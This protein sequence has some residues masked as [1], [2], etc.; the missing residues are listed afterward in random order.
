MGANVQCEKNSLTLLSDKRTGRLSKNRTDG[1]FSVPL[2]FEMSHSPISSD[3][4]YRSIKEPNDICKPNDI[5]AL[6]QTMLLQESMFKEQL[7]ELHRLYQVQMKLMEETKKNRLVRHLHSESSTLNSSSHYTQGLCELKEQ[8]RIWGT[9][10]SCKPN[11]SKR[12]SFLSSQINSKDF[13][14]DRHHT[15]RL[16]N[17]SFQKSQRP[18]IDLEQPAEQYMDTE[19][20]YDKLTPRNPFLQSTGN[21][22]LQRATF[23]DPQHALQ[24][25]RTMNMSMQENCSINFKG[26]PNSC[27]W[28]SNGHSFMHDYSMQIESPFPPVAL[29]SPKNCKV[30]DVKN[31]SSQKK[32]ITSLFGVPLKQETDDR[33]LC[34]PIT[35]NC[36]DLKKRASKFQSCDTHKISAEQASNMPHWLLKGSNS[37]SKKLSSVHPVHQRQQQLLPFSLQSQGEEVSFFENRALSLCATHETMAVENSGFLLGTHQGK[38]LSDSGP[39]SSAGK[40]PGL[41]QPCSLNSGTQLVL[42]S[43]R[44]EG[45]QGVSTVADMPLTMITKGFPVSQVDVAPA[46]FIS[47]VIISGSPNDVCSV[48]R[49]AVAGHLQVSAV[50][51]QNQ[52]LSNEFLP[53]SMSSRLNIFSDDQTQVDSS[54]QSIQA[55]NLQYVGLEVLPETPNHLMT[56]SSGLDLRIGFDLN[57]SETLEQKK[58]AEIAVFNSHAT[59]KSVRNNFDLNERSS[60]GMDVDNHSIP[61]AWKYE[62]ELF[63]RSSLGMSKGEIAASTECWES[64]L[65]MSRSKS[66]SEEI[67]ASTV[68]QSQQTG[69]LSVRAKEGRVNLEE[70]QVTVN[71]SSIVAGRSSDGSLPISCES[72]NTPAI[73]KAKTR[74]DSNHNEACESIAVRHVSQEILD[75]AAAAAMI[76]MQQGMLQGMVMCADVYQGDKDEDTW[77]EKST[78][79]DDLSSIGCNKVN[80]DIDEIKTVEA[81]DVLVVLSFIS[82]SELIEDC[83]KDDQRDLEQLADLIPQDALSRRDVVIAGLTEEKGSSGG[84]IVV[85]DCPEGYVFNLESIGTKKK[86]LDSFELSVLNLKPVDPDS[87]KLCKQPIDRSNIAEECSPPNQRRRSSRRGRVGKDFQ[88]DMLPSIASLSRQEITEDLQIIEGLVKSTTEA[89]ERCPFSSKEDL[90]WSLPALSSAKPSGKFKNIKPCKSGKQHDEHLRVCSWGES[91]RRRRM[92][93]QRRMCLPPGI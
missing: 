9:S 81:A 82:A 43:S 38:I 7:Y 33:K 18:M 35:E 83:T 19:I 46:S 57:A 41:T 5:E 1:A 87:E 26:A 34:G 72:R 69:S 86:V 28:R 93:R 60:E 10:E 24:Q 31:S 47:K 15:D 63:S 85:E 50:E 45:L 2:F 17:D 89:V 91:T 25:E 90:P 77:G 48:Q 88:K 71:G 84:S 92:Q 61:T 3:A 58:G 39:G 54:L 42:P 11:A 73:F 30:E 27:K 53:N 74:D 6:K 16:E 40:G 13:N 4:N 22:Q 65:D 8:D 20:Q 21:A 49:A 14:K 76:G 75:E 67:T 29:V 36:L 78:S 23:M 56:R 52:R 80:N 59:L 44:F 70:D 51:N 62:S 68:L 37:S 66:I 12:L 55:V 79:R 64:L 32:S